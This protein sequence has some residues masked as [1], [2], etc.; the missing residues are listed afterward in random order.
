MRSLFIRI[1]ALFALCLHVAA[2]SVAIMASADR[3]DVSSFVCVTPGTAQTGAQARM[4]DRLS[5][6]LEP[7]HETPH[8]DDETCSHCI[9]AASIILP[10]QAEALALRYAVEAQAFSFFDPGLVHEPRGPPVGATG[11][12]L[13]QSI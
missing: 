6:L 9:V 13:L 7:G 10:D 11:P 2:P 12:P 8:L 5:E 3:M 1:F 4:A